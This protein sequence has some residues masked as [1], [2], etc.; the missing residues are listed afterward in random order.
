M[1]DSQRSML[2]VTDSQRSWL[3]QKDNGRIGQTETNNLVVPNQGPTNGSQQMVNYVG[4]K[5]LAGFAI[6]P[7]TG[8]SCRPAANVRNTETT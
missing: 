2:Y 8:G 5:M 1:T 3:Y 7:T 4:E 6:V